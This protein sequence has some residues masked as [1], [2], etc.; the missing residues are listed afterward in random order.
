MSTSGREADGG[1]VSHAVARAVNGNLRLPTRAPVCQ[2]RNVTPGEGASSP[3]QEETMQTLFLILG[4]MNLGNG[5]W[6]LVAPESW[7]LN[8]PAAVPDT[9]PLNLHFVR[10][11]GVVYSTAGAA[12]LV[13]A[14]RPSARRGVLLGVTAFYVGH[15]LLH[16]DDIVAGRLPASHWAID[17]PGVF[18]PAVLLVVVCLP[19]FW[20]ER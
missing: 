3:S 1:P 15:A 13:G 6:M 20:R 17:F 12:L 2:M 18:L 7:Y 4:L 14:F 9:G 5:L 10:D 19:R 16:V 11:I 8:L